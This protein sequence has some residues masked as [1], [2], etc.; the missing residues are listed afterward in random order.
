MRTG[1]ERLEENA[2]Y[3][4]QML[5]TAHTNRQCPPGNPSQAPVRKQRH[6]LWPTARWPK[7]MLEK[8][9]KTARTNHIESLAIRGIL[10]L[11]KRL[12]KENE[13]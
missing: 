5:E 8:L 1:R 2:Q 7:S 9:L 12:S 3:A 4:R 11:S 10:I 13:T 6:F